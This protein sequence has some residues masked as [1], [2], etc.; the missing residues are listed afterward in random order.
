MK[1]QLKDSEN[2]EK[3]LREELIE[4]KKLLQQKSAELSSLQNTRST[5]QIVKETAE[6]RV[7]GEFGALLSIQENRLEAQSKELK[8]LGEA[9]R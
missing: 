4:T 8:T 6:A 9:K 3:S 5:I 7:K 1:L 2:K